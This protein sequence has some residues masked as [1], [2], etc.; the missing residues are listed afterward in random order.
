M[1]DFTLIDPL[2]G[3]IK[4][5]DDDRLV[6]SLYQTAPLARLRDISL[7]SVPSSMSQ[8]GHASSRFEH[9]AGVAYLARE[10]CRRKPK[11]APF[12]G[13]L[14]AAALLHD[15]GSVPFSHTAEIFQFDSTGRTH[16]Q[17]V[18]DVLQE[19]EIKRLL[20]EHG[21]SAE[22]VLELI[23]G[24]HPVL[25]GIV[26]GSIDIDNLDNSARLI[27][28]MGWVKEP[29]YDPSVLIDAFALRHD[30]LS[31]DAAYLQEMMGWRNC[32]EQL[33]GSILYKDNKLAAA[34]MLYRA[35]ESAYAAGQLPPE[36]FAL[37]EGA[38]V[39]YL[40]SDD[41]P[42][43]SRELI[44]RCV[45]WLFYEKAWEWEKSSSRENPKIKRLSGDWTARKDFADRL[46]KGL[47][48]KP[49]RLAV[50]AGRDKGIKPIH[51][52]FFGRDA[53]ACEELFSKR[54]QRQRLTIFLHPDVRADQD[55]IADLVEQL[56][57]DVEDMDD[58]HTFF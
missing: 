20:K 22:Q 46:A 11:F 16:E 45:R 27:R 23:E 13:E 1:T 47:K 26:A 25:G 6:T 49:E 55:R 54:E 43:V 4:H 53:G 19:K 44:E 18:A 37:G 57:E 42:K 9:S 50:H 41:V 29:P 17:A 40:R 3:T 38:A 35:L 31:L 58:G 36:F 21:V 33:Y 39:A 2:Y 5:G 14:A 10:L 15:T 30:K 52:P 28:S 56:L 32:R 34:C 24:R 12:R 8:T 7:S 51:L 48:I